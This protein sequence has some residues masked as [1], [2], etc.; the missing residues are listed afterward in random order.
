MTGHC[1]EAVYRSQEVIQI[2]SLLTGSCGSPEHG[3]YLFV[4]NKGD[5]RRW[6]DAQ[7]IGCQPLRVCSCVRQG[8]DLGHV[9]CT[10]T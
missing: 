6:N 3:C 7:Q 9:T 2:F 4:Y 10:T 1:P 5:G 8:W